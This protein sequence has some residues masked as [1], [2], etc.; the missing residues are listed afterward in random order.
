MGKIVSN[1]LKCFDY[2]TKFVRFVTCNGEDQ[3]MEYQKTKAA[4][5]FFLDKAKENGYV[6]TPM[7]VIKLVY[8]A[9]G[10]NLA[11]LDRPLI[12]DH[13]E[14]WKFGAVIPSLYHSLKVYGSGV[15]KAPLLNTDNMYY[16][17]VY[18]MSPYELYKKYPDSKITF[19]FLP[20]EYEVMSA[21]WD[22]H[23]GKSG[24]ELSSYIHQPNTPWTQVWERG[25]KYVNGAVID[26]NLIK[27]YYIDKISR[28]HE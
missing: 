2:I 14:A 27:Q 3:I 23:K 26:N 13:V 9:H 28:K 7:Q 22:I 24:F 16:M 4:C 21:I 10:Y 8:F 15:I 19:D 1:M 6:L 17:D 11:I 20:E 5:N 12:D 25:G 18:C